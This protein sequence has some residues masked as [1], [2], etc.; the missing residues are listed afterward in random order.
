MHW[1]IA[2]GFTDRKLRPLLPDDCESL[3]VM[4]NTPIRVGQGILVWETGSTLSADM[5]AKLAE[6]FGPIALIV[7]VDSEHMDIAGAIAGCSPAFAAMFIEALS[8]A[9]VKYGLQ[10]A[11]ALEMA[12]RVLEGT[13]ALFMADHNHPGVMKDSVCSPGG[14]TIRGVSQLEKDGFR[15]DIIDAVDAV[16]NRQ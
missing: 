15:G 6:L 16:M 11:Q 12:A 14:T 1:C 10:R 3:C 8:D 9:G 7:P 13:G 2:A 5:E 4:P